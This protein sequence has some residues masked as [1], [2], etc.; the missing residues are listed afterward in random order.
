MPYCRNCGTERKAS[1]F[2]CKGCDV[3]TDGRTSDEFGLVYS[4]RDLLYRKRGLRHLLDVAL[5]LTSSRICSGLVLAELL[6]HHYHLNRGDREPFDKEISE[7]VWAP[8]QL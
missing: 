8:F 3:E 4:L 2:D 6:E 1:L 7:R 5:V